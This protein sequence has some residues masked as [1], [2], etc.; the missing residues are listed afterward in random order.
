LYV[1]ASICSEVHGIGSE[2]ESGGE[3]IDGLIKR[4]VPTMVTDVT[5]GANVVLP[6]AADA[7]FR[8]G[9]GYTPEMEQAAPSFYMAKYRIL[10]FG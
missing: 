6:L 9:E 5:K 8:P 2:A 4:T 7:S 10:R 1:V 3:D